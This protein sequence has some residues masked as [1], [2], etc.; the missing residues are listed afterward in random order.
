MTRLGEIDRAH[1]LLNRCHIDT[2]SSIPERKAGPMVSQLLL[3]HSGAVAR[4]S[5]RPGEIH[6]R[7]F[8]SETR[9]CRS[10]RGWHV[11]SHGRIGAASPRRAADPSPRHPFTR[12]IGTQRPSD[13]G[14]ALVDMLRHDAHSSRLECAGTRRF[15][16]GRID[17]RHKS[18]SVAGDA[19]IDQ[20][21]SERAICP[22]LTRSPSVTLDRGRLRPARRSE[23]PIWHLAV[24]RARCPRI[25]ARLRST[26][27]WR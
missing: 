21:D 7:L 16:G 13:R 20:R 14:C 11:T 4:A 19:P 9:E 12:G 15:H 8:T 22:T 10:G 24:H 17:V 1:D 3:D 5:H 25:R 2:S 23:V 6:A 18:R 26:K 27:L